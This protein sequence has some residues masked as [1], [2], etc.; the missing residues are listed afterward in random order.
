M[1]RL[2]DSLLRIESSSCN[3]CRTQVARNSQLREEWTA[4][5]SAGI[6]NGI[7]L[8][9]RSASANRE[10]GA[11]DAKSIALFYAVPIDEIARRLLLSL[12]QRRLK[13]VQ[14]PA[15]GPFRLGLMIDLRVDGTPA[16][17]GILVDLDLCRDASICIGVA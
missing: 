17:H 13:Q 14:Q 7:E 12:G 10:S 11:I 5:G 15:P 4:R 16:V 2:D 6:T 3:H 8:A 9:M 1:R